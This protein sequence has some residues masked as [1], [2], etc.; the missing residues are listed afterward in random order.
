MPDA[1]HPAGN[2]PVAPPRHALRGLILGLIVFVIYECNAREVGHLDTAPTTFLASALAKGDGPFLD[3][4]QTLLTE[5]DG[6]LQTYAVRWGG[7]VLSRYPIAPALMV[8]PIVWVEYRVWKVL[9]PNWDDPNRPWIIHV[10]G[11]K[12]ASK[13]AVALL[14]TLTVVLIF[15]LLVRLDLGRVAFPAALAAGLGSDFWTIGSQSLWQHGP[16]ALMLTCALLALAPPRPSRLRLLLGGAATGMMVACRLVDVVYAFAILGCLTYR[17]RGRIGWFLPGPILI[18][19]LLFGYNFYYFGEWAGGQAYLESIHPEVH[20]VAGPWSGSILGGLA[21]TLFSPARGLFV[22]SPWLLPSF[23]LLPW[24]LGRLK[25]W[26]LV[27]TCVVALAPM[28]LVLSKYAVWWGGHCFGPRYWTDSTPLFAIVFA[29]ALDWSI[30]RFRP[31]TYLFVPLVAIAVAFQAIGVF[32]FP[33]D[34]NLK[35]E[36][37]DRHHERLWDWSDTELTRCLETKLG[38][39]LNGPLG[40]AP[41]AP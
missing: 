17:E 11:A 16:A 30:S 33:S 20:G 25:P 40:N 3:R 34:W 12:S 23:L 31:L 29:L 4:Y 14:A 5:P 18:A 32:T 6:R 1:L 35:P 24:T 9:K 21:G 2:P 36:N 39:D 22:F 10:I 41:Q 13:H 27:R 26:P 15:R 7:H 38:I 19:A 28:L 37:V 8:A